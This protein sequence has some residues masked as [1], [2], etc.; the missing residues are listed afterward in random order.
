MRHESHLK[1]LSSVLH[2]P[3]ILL[4]RQTLVPSN[5]FIRSCCKRRTTLGFRRASYILRNRLYFEDTWADFTPA[6]FFLVHSFP[7]RDSVLPQFPKELHFRCPLA[8]YVLKALMNKTSIYLET[9]VFGILVFGLLT[10]PL[11]FGAH[12]KLSHPLIGE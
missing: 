6:S 3:C 8:L 10:K 12:S 11:E 4:Q 9:H 2:S 1:P 5:V 7:V